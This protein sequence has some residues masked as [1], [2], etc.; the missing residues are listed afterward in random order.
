MTKPNSGAKKGGLIFQR[1]GSNF[2][3]NKISQLK[4][5]ELQFSKAEA[6]KKIRVIVLFLKL[7][8]GW[9]YNA[10]K[11]EI[12]LPNNTTGTQRHL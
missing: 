9:I 6:H 7:S 1:N 5:N 8:R 4:S 11:Q 12:S 3:C 10:S 2:R